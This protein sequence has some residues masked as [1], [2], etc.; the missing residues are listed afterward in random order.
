[1]TESTPKPTP[2]Q[3]QLLHDLREHG[4]HIAHVPAHEGAPEYSYTVGLWHQYEQPEVIVF[5]LERAAADALLQLLTD[6]VDEGKR[7]AAGSAHDGLLHGY[8]ARF[9]AVPPAHAASHCPL[10]QWAYDGAQPPFVQLVWPDK[11]GRWPWQ[12]DV[13]EGF[14]ELQPVLELLPVE[15]QRGESPPTA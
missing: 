7:F 9:R 15:T 11:Q 1:M 14:A 10:A 5:G 8:P 12:D 6:D 4:V 3:Q 13:R 2:E